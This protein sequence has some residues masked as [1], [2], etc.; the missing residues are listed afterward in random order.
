MLDHL[1]DL[2]ASQPATLADFMDTLGLCEGPPDYTSPD[3]KG[4]FR[5]KDSEPDF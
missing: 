5:F 4:D 2:D 1:E 3:Y